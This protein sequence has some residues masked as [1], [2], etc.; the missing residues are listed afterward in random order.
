[1]L[2]LDHLM[3]KLMVMLDNDFLTYDN[4]NDYKFNLFKLEI[5]EFERHSTNE[6]YWP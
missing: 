1:M 3:S 6:N 2:W 5:K 4:D